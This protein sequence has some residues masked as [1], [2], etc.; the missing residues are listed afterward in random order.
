MELLSPQ[1]QV[2][3]PLPSPLQH[4]LN[5]YLHN[6]KFKLKERHQKPLTTNQ[7]ATL[8]EDINLLKHSV[9]TGP[10]HITETGKKVKCESNPAS[11]KYKEII[12][13]NT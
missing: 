6:I 8:I 7:T 1:G 9:L 12:Y 2:I 5:W 10:I 13:R 3:F 11:R 4:S